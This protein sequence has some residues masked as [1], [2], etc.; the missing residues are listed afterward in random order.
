[1]SK[2]KYKC[3]ICKELGHNKN[4]CDLKYKKDD[5]IK[6][7]II[8]R[9]NLRNDINYRSQNGSIELIENFSLYDKTVKNIIEKKKVI[10]CL[11][12][13]VY[14]L[15]KKLCKDPLKGDVVD[16]Q[17]DYIRVFNNK[18]T[19]IQCE[20]NNLNYQRKYML[21]Y[22]KRIL[23]DYYFIFKDILINSSN[24]INHIETN[25]E[26]LNF[27]FNLQDN[28]KTLPN[29]LSDLIVSYLI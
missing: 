7:F 8:H 14:K 13:S 22:K 24:I 11:K 26:K 5:I 1:M 4:N 23:T 18:F 3:S 20:I 17:D 9:N 6:K 10:N 16:F 15:S 28:N 12:Y 2:K 27:W 29:E 25:D 21:R 19:S